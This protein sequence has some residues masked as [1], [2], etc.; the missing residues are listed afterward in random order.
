MLKFF[1]PDPFLMV[2]GP[3]FG[4]LEAETEEEPPKIEG[5]SSI[6]ENPTPTCEQCW[7]P[8]AADVRR[9]A[10]SL[11]ERAQGPWEAT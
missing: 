11:G 9:R 1:I 4:P 2:P 3:E 6:C 7:G 10:R 5:R 8:P